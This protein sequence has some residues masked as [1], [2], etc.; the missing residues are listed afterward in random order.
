MVRKMLGFRRGDTEDIDTFM[1]RTNSSIRNLLNLHS[2]RR[3]DL[4]SHKEVFKWAGWLARL[5]NLDPERPTFDVFRYRDWN[6]IQE[7]ADE[8]RGRQLHCRNL[9]TWRWERP[10]YLYFGRGWQNIATDEQIWMSKVEKFLQWRQN[11]R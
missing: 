4:V 5:G 7:I 11:H 6:W 2:V 8:N 3:W 9:K 1:H 10:I